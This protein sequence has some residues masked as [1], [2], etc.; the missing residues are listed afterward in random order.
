MAMASSDQQNGGRHGLTQVA[1][2]NILTLMVRR[3]EA[4]TSRLEDI[5]SSS[6]NANGESPSGAPSSAPSTLVA[7]EVAPTPAAA[8]KPPAESVPPAIEAFDELVDTE[9]NKWLELSGML[10]DVIGGQVCLDI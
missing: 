7:G 9:L 4:A 3:L 5:A 6:L 2:D 1:G 8:P 10:G